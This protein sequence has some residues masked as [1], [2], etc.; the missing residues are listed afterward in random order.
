MIVT[1]NKR[2]KFWKL[3]CQNHGTVKSFRLNIAVSLWYKENDSL[4]FKGSNDFTFIKNEIFGSTDDLFLSLF[5]RLTP[6]IS[7][8]RS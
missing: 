1:Q 3:Y 7:Q 5:N 4:V 6:L 8:L 2:K